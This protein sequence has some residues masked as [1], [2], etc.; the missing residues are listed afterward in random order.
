MKKITTFLFIAFLAATSQ[1]Q[2][3]TDGLRYST[4]QNTGTARFT[5][6]S[7]A[8]GALGGDFS[9]MSINPAGGA[10]FLDS[11]LLFSTALFDID[12]KANYFNST[13]NSFSDTASINQLGAVFVLNNAN[14][15]SKF[16]KLTLGLNFETTKNFNDEI[17]IAGN[18]HTSIGAFF[19]AQAQGIPLN[20]LQNS[21]YQFLGQ[22][23]GTAA[24]NAFLG[25]QAYLFDP[26]DPNNP[27][28]SSYVSNI[29]GNNFNQ[30][31]IYLSQGNN[32]K[33][34]IN[35]ATQITDNYFFGINLN[36]HT[37]SYD[38]STYLLEN[39]NNPG[40]TVNSVGFENN[41]SVNGAGF[42]VQIG[43]IARVAE[44]LRLGLSLDTPT[45]Y[46][47]SEET[48][49]NLESSRVF[50][51]QIINEF[52]DPRVINVYEDYTLKTPAK[53]TA[54]A[55][56]IFGQKGLI[57]LDYSYKDYSSIDFSYTFDD[58]PY[59][60]DLNRTIENSLKGASSFNAGAEYRLRQLSFRGG[61]HYEES[62]YQ[63]TEVVGDLSG[64]SLGAGYNF[65]NYTLD[66]AYSRSEQER[67][68]QLYSVGLTDAA[69][70]NSIYSNFMVSVGFTF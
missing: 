58:S 56:Y 52:I 43:A 10:V 32:S 31:Y 23:Q 13:E 19:L 1:A 61:F 63:E 15:E 12:N 44:K 4:D 8:M 25:Y 50:E 49:Q 20:Q 33:F 14:K 21:D 35:F 36:T 3:S 54:S 39:N 7:G 57:S 66:F 37:I 34:T 69:T 40:S 60:N 29:A 59:F 42:S 30:K 48:T 26:V 24:Q 68:Q 55:A 46:L 38:Q 22:T 62:P 9:A 70:I 27:S 64:F 16:K 67:N 6:L 41:L 11:N 47:I 53:V 2:N 45:W 65:G 5:A 51:N 28:N 18:G 17:F